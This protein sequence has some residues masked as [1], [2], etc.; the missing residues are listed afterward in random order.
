MSSSVWP[1]T[2]VAHG[3]HLGLDLESCHGFSSHYQ[4]LGLTV[5][6]DT[7]V[8]L[9]LP[10]LLALA[11]V[12]TMPCYRSHSLP[13]QISLGMSIQNSLFGHGIYL[14]SELSVSLPYSPMGYGWRQSS[15]GSEM[16]CVALCEVV[17]HPDV[18]FQDKGEKQHHVIGLRDDTINDKTLNTEWYRVPCLFVRLIH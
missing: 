5:I 16:S 8:V 12:A 14:S 13:L 9:L 18:K 6:L 3:A 7:N 17:D 4:M 10:E 2:R 15:V 11:T 1:V